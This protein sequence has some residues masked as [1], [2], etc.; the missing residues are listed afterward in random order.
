MFQLKKKIFCRYRDY[1]AACDMISFSKYEFLYLSKII[2]IYIATVSSGYVHVI[3]HIKI[4]VV[5]WPI[6]VLIISIWRWKVCFY[7]HS[8]ESLKL[9]VKKAI[10]QILGFSFSKLGWWSCLFLFYFLFLFW[11]FRLH[12][13]GHL[14]WKLE[15]AM[16][17]LSVSTDQ[18]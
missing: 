2:F 6:F 14:C 18:D 17:C 7:G 9:W 5:F 10:Y 1:N 3:L 12:R 11:L 13:I 15:S 16:G 8:K 4:I